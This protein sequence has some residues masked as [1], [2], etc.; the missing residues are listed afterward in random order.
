MLNQKSKLW[1][2][3]KGPFKH[4]TFFAFCFILLLFF[5]SS[6]LNAFS[7]K[8]VLYSEDHIISIQSITYFII[9]KNSIHLGS[10]LVLFVFLYFF[11]IK[12]FKPRFVWPMF[13]MGIFTGGLGFLLLTQSSSYLMG[14]SSGNLSWFFCLILLFPK[15]DLHF[16]NFKLQ[17]RFFAV[18]IILFHIISFMLDAGNSWQAHLGTIILMPIVIFYLRQKKS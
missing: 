10:N 12:T 17:F 8:L 2:K 5:F 18:L 15:Q 11:M 13:F 16:Y 6:T 4:W 1:Q 7:K 14:I 3:N 9:H